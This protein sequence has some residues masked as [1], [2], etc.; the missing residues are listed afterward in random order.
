MNLFCKLSDQWDLGRAVLVNWRKNWF[1]SIFTLTVKNS[2]WKIAFALLPPRNNCFLY[3]FV[4]R[5]AGRQC[6]GRR[7]TDIWPRLGFMIFLSVVGWILETCP[8][9]SYEHF[10]ICCFRALAFTTSDW[11]H[12]VLFVLH[13]PKLMMVMFHF[14]CLFVCLSVHGITQKVLNEFFV[15]FC[16]GM[17]CVDWHWLIRFWCWCR[18]GNFNGIYSQSGNFWS[19]FYH[20]RVG[21]FNEFWGMS[22]LDGGLLSRLLL[23]NRV[24][25]VGW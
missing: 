13:L 25:V 11:V 3:Q 22:C 1:S 19:N 15:K 16:G 12:A 14:V 20:F 18:F 2:F 7:G 24:L 4:Y 5:W 10:N 9:S 8:F 17:A 23:V 6:T 21:Q